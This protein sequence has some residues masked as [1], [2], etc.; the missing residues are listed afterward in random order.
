MASMRNFFTRMRDFLK[1]LFGRNSGPS[2]IDVHTPEDSPDVTPRDTYPFTDDEEESKPVPKPDTEPKPIESKEVKMYPEG[3]TN[4]EEKFEKT[5]RD[6]D[7]VEYEVHESSDFDFPLTMLNPVGVSGFYY[8]DGQTKEAIVLHFTVGFL[9]GDLATLVEQDSHMSVPFVVGRNGVAYQLFSSKYWSYHL[10]RGALGGNTYGSK[11]TIAIELS[12]IGPLARVGNELQ[13]VYKQKYCSISEKQF[14]VEL[15]EPYRE[16]KYFATFTDKQYTCLKSLIAYLCN[17]YG[18]PNKFMDEDKR[19]DLF[20]SEDE[21]KIFKGICS[22]V[23]YRGYGK[24]DIG[25][26]FEWDKIALI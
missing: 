5:H 22:H 1:Q 21:A 16:Y 9:P 26:A 20:A 15:E 19:Y 6:S 23:N 24:V 14:Y 4:Y 17:R 12:N 18:I 10:G 25:P 13:S 3:M 2:S 7:G 11:R 8:P